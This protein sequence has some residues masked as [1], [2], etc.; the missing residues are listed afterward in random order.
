[1]KHF[2][3]CCLL[4][5]SQSISATNIW[6]ERQIG[7]PW[8]PANK[9][10]APLALQ[11]WLL[12][13]ESSDWPARLNALLQHSYCTEQLADVGTFATS[14][15]F[16][17]GE[18]KVLLTQQ[19]QRQLA[20]SAPMQAQPWLKLS[21]EQA[22]STSPVYLVADR[23]RG[24]IQSVMVP[25]EQAPQTLWQ[26]D[27]V[28]PLNSVGFAAPLVLSTADT[29]RRQAVLVLPA[30]NSFGVQMLDPSNGRV[31]PFANTSTNEPMQASA[32][33]AVLDTDLN[34][35]LDRIY[36]I[37]EDGQ[38]YRLQV[39]PNLQVQASLVADLRQAGWTYKVAVTASRARWPIGHGWQIGDVVVIQS[40]AD[41]RQQLL[42]LKIPE[43]NNK[44]S[45]YQQ[46]T[47]QGL[48]SEP[49]DSS[50]GWRLDLPGHIAAM[51]SI[52]AGVL[53]L[54]LADSIQH[55]AGPKKM[56]KL[57]ALHLYHGNAVYPESLLRI[58]TPVVAKLAISAQNQGL[59]LMAESQSIVPKML[60]VRGDCAG[61]SEVLLPS[62]F[63]KWQRIASYQPEHGAY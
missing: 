9:S 50:D 32:M 8:Q 24:F 48:S 61:C 63:P 40:Q 35:A 34:G 18:D 41:Q 7:Q 46:L 44:V 36:Q 20:E 38:L 12:D 62:H 42:V 47:A 55:C 56:D 30:R 17:L 29:P 43:V 19:M 23:A 14:S 45:Q 33:P 1:M 27:F 2:M 25:P 22:Q 39:L 21:A 60:G 15:H 4:L 37:S 54:P 5:A 58:Q 49:A 3:L 51:P 13:Q 11:N 16:L 28:P 59:M 31:I 10:D 52:M 6:L 57:L 26:F 53:Y